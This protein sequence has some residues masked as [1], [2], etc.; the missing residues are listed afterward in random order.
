MPATPGVDSN[1]IGTL[2]SESGEV[3]VE[4]LGEVDDKETAVEIVAKSGKEHLQK[5]FSEDDKIQVSILRQL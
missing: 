1:M 3:E 4:V 5:L 2:D